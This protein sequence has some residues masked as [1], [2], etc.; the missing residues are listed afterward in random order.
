MPCLSGATTHQ[1]SAQLLAATRR[2]YQ[3]D[4]LQRYFRHGSTPAAA[5]R[6]WVQ[7]NATKRYRSYA[8]LVQQSQLSCFDGGCNITDCA[9][10]LTQP[11]LPG[12]VRP[13]L[14]S[15]CGRRLF[16]PVYSTARNGTTWRRRASRKGA[17]GRQ[18]EERLHQMERMKRKRPRRCNHSRKSA[19]CAEWPIDDLPHCAAA[20]RQALNMWKRWNRCVAWRGRG[21]C[22]VRAG[23]LHLLGHKTQQ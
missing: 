7:H 9:D 15:G 2:R 12:S 20:V 21:G 11:I 18:I 17:I 1:G 19:A 8:L 6:P 3:P 13:R 23:V 16:C 22:G 4:G 14:P 5:S 10:A